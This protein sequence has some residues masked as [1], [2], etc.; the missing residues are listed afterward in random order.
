MH[1]AYGVID[2]RCTMHA[3]S[4]TPDAQGITPYAKYAKYDTAC[5][6][7]YNRRTIRAAWQPLKGIAIK[8][9]YV[10]ELTYHT[11]TK[12][13]KFKGTTKQ[14]ISANSKQNSKRL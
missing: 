2:I 9:I 4:L 1:D 12:K 6:V 5:T 8:N 3:L 13:C 10:R 11:T 7:H 14:K